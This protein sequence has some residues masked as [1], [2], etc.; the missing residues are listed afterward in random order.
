MKIIRAP[1]LI[2]PICK[3]RKQG[4]KSLTCGK[5]DK[6]HEEYRQLQRDKRKVIHR[7]C[8]LCDNIIDHQRKI[9]CGKKDKG[10][11]E[12]RKK[13]HAEGMRKAADSK[14]ICAHWTRKNYN[15]K[16]FRKISK[17]YIEENFIDLYGFL[18]LH[19]LMSFINCGQPQASNLCKK[20]KVNYK[21]R[22][23]VS[24]AES[25]IIRF[26]NELKPELEIIHGSRQIISPHE[27]DIYMPKL[28][29]A[30]E[31]NGLIWHSSGKHD[32]S[33]F[34]QPEN[35][36]KHVYKTDICETKNIKLLQILDIE[37]DPKFA[38]KEQIALTKQRIKE[39][40]LNNHIS[41]VIDENSLLDRRFHS[42]LDYPNAQI[43]E[44]K[45]WSFEENK[46][47]LE[48]GGN[49]DRVIYDAGYL[50]LIKEPK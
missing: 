4:K 42:K 19:A 11:E 34:N 28:K 27:L 18:R 24:N 16:N 7:K 41:V 22:V 25:E 23:K 50:K 3:E 21:R 26:I 43:V 33:P 46:N 8:P 15:C 45:K 39:F 10:H 49:L 2:C 14:D 13:A 29:L 36:T 17:A 30:I 9:T 5:K 44:P 32:Y 20:L 35:P 40:I 47:I 1:H 6:E 38:T 48:E 37:W 12:Y 31:Y